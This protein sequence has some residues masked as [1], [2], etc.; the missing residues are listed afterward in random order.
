M[1]ARPRAG[2]RRRRLLFGRLTL[3]GGGLLAPV[4]MLELALRLAGPVLPGEYQTAIFDVPS[5]ELI[6]A[7]S[8]RRGC[9]MTIW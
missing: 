6:L 8:S 1:A 4:L 5:L 7:S 3:L 9:R 2:S